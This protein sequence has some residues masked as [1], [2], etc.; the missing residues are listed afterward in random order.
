MEIFLEGLVTDLN[1][2]LDNFSTVIVDEGSWTGGARFIGLGPQGRVDLWL[3]GHRAGIRPHTHHQF[4]SGL[5]LD[6]R[7]IGDPLGP[8]ATGWEVGA[9]WQGFDQSVSL[10]WNWERYRGDEFRRAGLL[11]WERIA[12]NPDEIRVRFQADWI[13]GMGVTGVNTTVRLGY[14]HVTRFNFTDE[15]RSNLMAQVKVGYSW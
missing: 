3:E 12:D 10:N 11:D 7:V 8:M 13:R 9:A 2:K 15:N 6:D 4:T 14:E 5:T 1:E